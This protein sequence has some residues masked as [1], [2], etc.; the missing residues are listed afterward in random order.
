LNVNED[1]NKDIAMDQVHDEHQEP[2][3]EPSQTVE[4]EVTLATETDVSS[5]ASL[6]DNAA[7]TDAD[8]LD[9]QK[10]TQD[11]QQELAAVKAQLED[12][13][14]QYMR[15]AADFENFRK[16]TQKEKEDL[17]IQTKSTTITELLPVI[18][19]F[20]RARSQIRPKTEEENTIHKSYQSVYKQFVDCLKKLGV[21]SMNA[22]GKEFDPGLHE[23]VIR[24][25]TDQHPE[26][27]V[28][29]ELVRGYLI[30]DKVLRHAMVKVAA[31]P[32]AND[33][34]N[35]PESE[36]SDPEN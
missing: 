23:A 34:A 31:P 30:G 28:I 24:E 6:G 35:N 36:N 32:D 8:V 7:A 11:L 1:T 15:L 20:D 5:G 26:G 14:S 27:T 16:R 22:K 25:P 3:A 17:E 29:E 21:S 2:Q 19:N 12:R 18:D 4:S 33:A 9:Y 13:S 10:L